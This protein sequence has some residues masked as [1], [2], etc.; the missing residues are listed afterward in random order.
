[1]S[2]FPHPIYKVLHEDDRYSVEGYQFVR[3]ALSYAQDVMGLGVT[4]SVRLAN[5]RPP[6][7]TLLVSN[8]VKQVGSTLWN[9]LA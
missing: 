3:E 4:D 7:V 9:N 2:E 8:C 6:T 1:M 5:P